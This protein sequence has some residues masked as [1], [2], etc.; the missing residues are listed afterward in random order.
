[1]SY[2]PTLSRDTSTAE[3]I[4]QQNTS[5]GNK[6]EELY[7]HTNIH[8]DTPNKQFSTVN[9]N[10]NSILQHP[11]VLQRATQKNWM[12]TNEYDSTKV[13]GIPNIIY[14]LRP[15]TPVILHIYDVDNSFTTM[16]TIFGKYLDIGGIFHTT[17]E[18]YGKEYSYNMQSGISSSCRKKLLTI[19]TNDKMPH[20][21]RESIT[22]GV[23]Q[24]TNSEVKLL[25]QTMKEE[26]NWNIE[27]Y[28]LLSKNCCHFSREF[29]DHL[30]GENN[31][32]NI[33][34]YL[35]SLAETLSL[36]QQQHHNRSSFIPLSSS[37]RQFLSCF[38]SDHHQS[39]VVKN[40]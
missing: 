7:L 16:N 31:N 1:M 28:D 4:L 30:L 37:Y 23:S 6:M 27:S 9:T 35:F 10:H 38:S 12:N 18:I 34:S 24:L 21:Y 17:I 20:S 22:L 40:N 26:E 25:L 11:I 5:N 33:P 15:K 32:N 14:I 36:A 29:A 19:T 3:S 2:S 39:E 13:N 8:S